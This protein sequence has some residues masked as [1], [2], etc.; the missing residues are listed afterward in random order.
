LA[1][2]GLDERYVISGGKIPK[3][4]I[5]FSIVNSRLNSLRAESAKYLDSVLNV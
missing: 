2:L 1:K 4:L 5:D 3:E